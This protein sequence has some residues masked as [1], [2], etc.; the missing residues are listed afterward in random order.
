MHEV[1]LMTFGE[2]LEALKRGYPV[3]REKWG[4]K[5]VFLFLRPSD[6]IPVKIVV[7][8]V[9]S[10]PQS[11]KT[12]FNKKYNSDHLSASENSGP[13][14]NFGGYICMKSDDDSIINGWSPS[15]TDMLSND[16]KAMYK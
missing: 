5:G 4:E 1:E 14:V 6:D 15:Q 9:K 10:L 12:F 7:D 16:W 8:V 3:A 13:V 2:A 11:V